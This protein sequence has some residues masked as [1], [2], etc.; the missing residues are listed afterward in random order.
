MHRATLGV[1]F[2]REYDPALIPT[3]ARQVE[4]AGLDDLWIIED[5]FYNGGLSGAAVALASTERISIGIGIQP[6]VVR[7]AAY[8]TMDLAT[9]ARI[10]PGRLQIGFGH[11]VADW[12]RQVGEFPSSQV[13]ALE[14]ITL[15]TR[16]LLRGETVSF[17]TPDVYLDQVKLEYPPSVV[18]PVSLGVTGP[19][20]LQMSGRAAD[21]TIL[22]EL[23]GPALVEESRIRIADGQAEVNRTG[24]HHQITV[25]THWMQGD[26]GPAVRST[27][28]QMVAERIAGG[29]MRQLVPA[30]FSG[31][32]Q[33]LLDEGGV[34]N[35]AARMPDAWLQEMTVSG[36]VADCLTQIDRLSAAGAHRIGLV[37][38]IG[39]P[40]ETITAWATELNAARA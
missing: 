12:I 9:L 32:A 23:T 34:A 2:L 25:F 36:T 24:E 16:Q 15:A 28:R 22:V 38:P 11:G 8:N 14:T 1:M 7:N 5:A 20:S 10:Y 4:A 37:P 21:G 29:S 33:R 17:N 40:L 30:G 18:P 39:T 6:A 31:D 35:L 27:W 3:F 13:G 26:D 19:K